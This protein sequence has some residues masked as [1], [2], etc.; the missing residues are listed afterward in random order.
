MS[1][2]SQSSA[3]SR[4]TRTPRVS[5]SS[6]ISRNGQ[7]RCAVPAFSN[8]WLCTGTNIA[9]TVPP[10]RTLTR[11]NRRTDA[12]P[13]ISFRTSGGGVPVACSTR[14]SRAGRGSSWTTLIQQACSIPER[15][16]QRPARPVKPGPGRFSRKSL[17]RDP[18]PR[19]V[20]PAMP[21]LCPSFGELLALVEPALAAF[22]VDG[23][24][25]RGEGT[26]A[27]QL[28]RWAELVA[29]WNQR[30]DLTAALSTAELVDLLVADAALIAQASA[31]SEGGEPE[32]WLDVGSGAGAPGLALALLRPESSMTLVEPRAKR[33]AFLR[34]ALAT[35]GR[36]DV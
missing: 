10:S 31:P 27:M 19:I 11:K 34:T 15:A 3:M 2:R 32:R 13:T 26:L 23:A 30:I 28:A 7:R 8:S 33:V 24:E 18:A 12:P 16:A 25:R 17:R 5:S 36:T 1:E 21:A 14:R 9:M 20:A 22:G 35:L 29:V 4:G 6:R